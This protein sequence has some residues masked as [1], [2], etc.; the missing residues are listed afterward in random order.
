MR[1]EKQTPEA[2][3][4]QGAHVNDWTKLLKQA[5][6]TAMAGQTCLVIAPKA[7]TAFN[8]FVALPEAMEAAEHHRCVNDAINR[9]VHFQPRGAVRFF[10]HDHPAWNLTTRRLQGYPHTTPIYVLEAST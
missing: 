1:G 6:V 9:E 2:D 7:Q 5:L 8:A 4:A 3:A 10:S